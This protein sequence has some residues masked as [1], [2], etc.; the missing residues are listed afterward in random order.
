MKIDKTDC[1]TDK[2]HIIDIHE[3]WPES[4]IDCHSPGWAGRRS[5]KAGVD[6]GHIYRGRHGEL[7]R[8][9]Y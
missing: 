1:D 7:G 8:E 4:C 2:G 3:I 6:G 9:V 5:Y